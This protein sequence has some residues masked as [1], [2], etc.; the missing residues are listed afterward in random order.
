MSADVSSCPGPDGHPIPMVIFDNDFPPE[1]A[2]GKL[3]VS[4]R[5]TGAALFTTPAHPFDEDV[6]P[7]LLSPDDA[8]ML[9]RLL[10]GIEQP[11][12]VYAMDMIAAAFDRAVLFEA[13]AEPKAI[14]P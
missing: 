10:L 14:E 8:A 5:G 3:A 12:T 2:G 9:G 13:N 7:I 1:V 11:A 4:F 6:T